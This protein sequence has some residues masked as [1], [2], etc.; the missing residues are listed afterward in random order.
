V[1]ATP[2]VESIRLKSSK[3]FLRLSRRNRS[4]IRLREAPPS[5]DPIR[6]SDTK[7]R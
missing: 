1:S 3:R 5:V 4:A 7:L 6:L 2:G